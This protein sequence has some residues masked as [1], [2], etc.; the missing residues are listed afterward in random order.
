V[1]GD[2]QLLIIGTQIDTAED[3]AYVSEIRGAAEGLP[4]IFLLNADRVAVW[5]A[6][7]EA[8]LFWHTAG[9]AIDENQDPELAEHFGI[10]TV[11]ARRAGWVPVVIA[12]GGKR[13][14]MEEGVS[15][16][17]ARDL[18]DLILSSIALTREENLLLTMSQQAEGRSMDF[19]AS[20]FDQRVL[21]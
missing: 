7:A 10:A 18:S 19:T 17:L 3:Q 6:L 4:V 14:I 13:E 16:F 11:E 8:K 21:K 5:Q 20:I 15:G 9:L 1:R 2:W 12:W